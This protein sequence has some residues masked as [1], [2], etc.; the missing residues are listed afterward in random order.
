MDIGAAFS[1]MFEDED[2]IKKIAIGG[3]IFLVAYIASMFLIGIVLFIPVAGYML[4]TLK[5]VRDQ[6]PRPL[7]EWT[8][9]GDLFSQGLPV[10]GIVFVYNSP[11]FLFICCIFAL[12]IPLLIDPNAVEEM[13]GLIMMAMLCLS[14]LI[15]IVSIVAS[16]LIPGALIRYAQY[17][18]FGSA[19]HLG[20]IFRF[21]TNNVGDYIIAALLSWVAMGLLAQ[22]G[23]IA[24]FIGVFFTSFWAI[25][26]SA[27]LFGQL[28]RNMEGGFN[29]EP[30]FASP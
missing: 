5:N 24:C 6:N 20:E 27:H 30:E 15:T 4:A 7:P 13:M 11:I 2:W 23:V 21:I 3:G 10:F 12:Y 28:A 19:F 18:T 8:D 17:G 16:V 29:A 14:C 1:Y 25:L 9:F 22:F 26:V